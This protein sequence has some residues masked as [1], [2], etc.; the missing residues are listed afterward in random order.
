MRSKGL[1]LISGC[2]IALILVLA[3]CAAPAA[4]TPSPTISA[5]ATTTQV[6]T[7]GAPATTTTAVAKP[8]GELIIAV[9]DFGNENFLPWTGAVASAALNNLVYDYLIYWD[10]VNLKFIPGLAESWEVSPD[11]LILTYHLRKGVQFSDGWGEFT[12][13]DVKYTFE[14][15]ASP[16]SIGKTSQCRRIA[17]MDTPDPYTLV[18]HFKDPYP[19]FWVDLSLGN[20]AICQG[21]VS[22]N[23]LETVGDRS[24]LAETDRHGPLEAGGEPVSV[25]LQ[26]RGP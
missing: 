9:Q 25:L 18:V 19:T 21:I 16:K 14:M 1:W 4:T 23:Y 26:T 12:S 10:N 11:G 17:S 15:Q 22:K 6:P 2:L 8:Q 7:S 5:P 24:S 3:A 13:A 20:S